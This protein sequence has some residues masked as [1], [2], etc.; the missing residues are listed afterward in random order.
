MKQIFRHRR[1]AAATALFH[2]TLIIL[3]LIFGFRP[4]EVPEEEGLLI[5][6]GVQETGSG[7]IEP[8]AGSTMPI[9]SAPSNLP[10]PESESQETQEEMLTQEFEESAAVET[11]KEEVKKPEKS[12]EEIAREKQIREEQDRERQAEL[13]R[14]RQ[15]E[16]ERQRIAEEERQI[17]EINARTQKAF[18]GGK[19]T[20]E[21]ES[22]G[23]GESGDPGNQGS[24]EG[25]TESGNRGPGGGIGDDGISFNLDGRSP[26]SLPKPDYNSQISGT[27]V[28]EVTV[29]RNGTVTRAVAGKKGSTI[30]DEYLLSVAKEAALKAKFDKKPSAPP[31]Q[32]G[33]ITYIFILD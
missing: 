1:G 11:K 19:N 6:F 30:L 14:Q 15:A 29:D 12:P 20:T 27:V 31:L 32:K 25:S 24:T 33:T 8:A 5:N 22:S 4:P 26:E 10:Q 16:I 2:G 13:E 23:E 7:N 28:V 18:S 3:F 21:T 17:E 9:E